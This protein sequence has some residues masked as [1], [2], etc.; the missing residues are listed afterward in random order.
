MEGGDKQH[1]HADADGDGKEDWVEIDG[2]ASDDDNEIVSFFEGLASDMSC[3]GIVSVDW[4]EA[5]AR[6]KAPKKERLVH[7]KQHEWEWTLFKEKGELALCIGVVVVARFCTRRCSNTLL[8]C[9]SQNNFISWVREVVT[10]TCLHRHHRHRC[11]CP[12]LNIRICIDILVGSVN[13]LP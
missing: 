7:V 6:N 13:H 9:S 3:R 5:S 1:E 8:P 10:K 12:C 4:Q 2:K 11:Y